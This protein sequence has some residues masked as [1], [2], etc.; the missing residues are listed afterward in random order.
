[1]KISRTFLTLVFTA[2]IIFAAAF[3]SSKIAEQIRNDNEIKRKE[4]LGKQSETA[5]QI[6]FWVSDSG[7]DDRN[8]ADYTATGLFVFALSTILA[9]T[10][11]KKYD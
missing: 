11:I 4:E 6:Q 7:E 1:M 8:C 9:A 5:G 2:L 3:Y 10:W